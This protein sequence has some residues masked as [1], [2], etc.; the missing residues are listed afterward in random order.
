MPPIR[1]SPRQR[2][3]AGLG[4]AG[5]TNSTAARAG[6]IDPQ[7]GTFCALCNHDRGQLDALLERVLVLSTVGTLRKVDFTS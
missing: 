4:I 1:H 2:H 6:S 3:D 5:G 7:L